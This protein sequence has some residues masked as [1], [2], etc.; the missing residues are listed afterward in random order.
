MRLCYGKMKSGRIGLTKSG[1]V[2]AKL[3]TAP[4]TRVKRLKI[5]GAGFYYIVDYGG[6]IRIPA[7]DMITGQ[8][9]IVGNL[10]GTYPKLFWA[11]RTR[12]PGPGV[13]FAAI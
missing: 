2:N 6:D 7:I 12:A 13:P 10:V 11:G 3:P 9:T 8:K 1:P 5:G 4:K